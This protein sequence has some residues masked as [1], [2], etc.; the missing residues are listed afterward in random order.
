MI[1]IV[2]AVLVAILLLGVIFKLV[3]VAIIVALAFG[4][5]MVLQNKFGNKRIK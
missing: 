1:G 2:I 4:V 5:V 3:K